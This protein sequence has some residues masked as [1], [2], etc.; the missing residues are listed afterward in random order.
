MATLLPPPPLDQSPA[1]PYAVIDWYLKV[2]RAINEVAQVNKHNDLVDI[3]G[4]TT[5][6]YF[7][8]TQQEYD[9]LGKFTSSTFDLSTGDLSPGEW[10]MHKNTATGLLYLFA[11]DGGTIKKVQLT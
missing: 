5:A 4:G 8:L 2:Q 6:E 10:R 3:Q 1:I 11:N 9:E 7:H